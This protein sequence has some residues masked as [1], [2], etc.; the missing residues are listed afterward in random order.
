MCIHVY[1]EDPIVQFHH[2][3]S[4]RPF[5]LCLL[6]DRVHVFLLFLTRQDPAITFAMAFAMAVVTDNS[7]VR[8]RDRILLS[9]LVF[10]LALAFALLAL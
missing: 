6:F 1:H 7:S 2:T 5:R 10:H 8:V 4:S 9:V 3:D